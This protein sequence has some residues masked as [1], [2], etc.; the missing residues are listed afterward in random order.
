MAP[1]EIAL[2]GNEW[3]DRQ[4]AGLALA[5]PSI[6]VSRETNYLLNPSNLDF[7]RVVDQAELLDFNLD[8]R[9]LKK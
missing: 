3:L 1:E 7:R 4:P 2:N 8:G 5:V 6:I 9:L